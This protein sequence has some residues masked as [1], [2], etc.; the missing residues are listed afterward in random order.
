MYNNRNLVTY[1]FDQSHVSCIGAHISD[2]G[3]LLFISYELNTLKMLIILKTSSKIRPTSLSGQI[4]F[5]R[6][7]GR[8]CVH[9]KKEI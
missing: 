9:G 2:L 6:E 8:L 5:Y 3:Y 7:T 1:F 4:T